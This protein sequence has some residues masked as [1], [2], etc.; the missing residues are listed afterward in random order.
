M[1]TEITAQDGAVIKQTTRIAVIGCPTVKKA[2]AATR[3][4]KAKKSSAGHG[5]GRQG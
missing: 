1:P 5:E 4:T 3:K 2:K